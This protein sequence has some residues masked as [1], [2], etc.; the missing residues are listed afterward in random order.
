MC[1]PGSMV[2]CFA[3]GVGPTG[4]PVCLSHAG[5][6]RYKGACKTA[7]TEK[8]TTKVG[9][10]LRRIVVSVLFARHCVPEPKT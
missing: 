7:Q 1:V 6:G 9:C 5:Y 2:N 8:E 4:A 10:S 3:K